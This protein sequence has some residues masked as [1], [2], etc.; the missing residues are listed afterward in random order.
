MVLSFGGPDQAA[1]VMP[2]L[3]NV[4]HGRA[5]PPQ[6]L[7]AV[8]QH[9]FLLGGKSPINEQNQA[10]IAAVIQEL[11]AHH[12]DLPVYWGNRNWHPLLPDT[13]RQMAEDGVRR[14]LVFVTS[15]FSSYSGCRQYLENIES[16][17]Q[18][19]GEAAPECDKLR[20]FYNHP[21]FIAAMADQVSRAVDSIS[22]DRRNIL[23]LFTAHSIP[24]S[25]ADGCD[26]VKQLQESC[27][28]VS[29]SVGIDNRRLVYQSRS[30]PPQSPWLE[31]D[32]VDVIRELGQSNSPPETVLIPIG[33]I[34][35]HMEV[36]FDLDV[37]A[38]QA[39]DEAGVHLVR[40]ATVGTHPRFVEMIRLLAEERLSATPQRL[41]TG[42]FG[43][44]HD[45]CPADCC[46]YIPQRPKN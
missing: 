39:A 5:I 21:G 17:R 19:V 4:T 25:M 37:E 10:L 34:S 36:M 44:H 8:A 23:L 45:I 43:P 32:V 12:I 28:L 11:R 38:K 46:K 20:A 26:Y 1:D 33:F 6:R 24:Q 9:Y 13:L 31:P 41:A 35:D 16:A 42:Q 15:I 2:F 22:A 29:E 30:G 14:S 7:E 18:E 27:R 3:Q 40:A